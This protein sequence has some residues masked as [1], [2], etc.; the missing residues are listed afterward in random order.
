LEEIGGDD[1]TQGK[2]RVSPPFVFYCFFCKEAKQ[3]E[4]GEGASLVR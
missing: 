1:F 3:K 2:R 4:E